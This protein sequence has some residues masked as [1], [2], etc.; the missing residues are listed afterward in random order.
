MRN[1]RDQRFTSTREAVPVVV[2][3]DVLRLDDVLRLSCGTQ[4]AAQVDV[5]DVFE[6]T[7]FCSRVLKRRMVKFEGKLP[8]NAY[9]FA[10]IDKTNPILGLQGA[11]VDLQQRHER[12]KKEKSSIVK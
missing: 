7:G 1:Q 3:P 9:F 6:N 8:L 2:G 4:T 11:G 10:N 12:K 5:G